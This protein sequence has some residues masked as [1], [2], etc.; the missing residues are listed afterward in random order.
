MIEQLLVGQGECCE[1]TSRSV[2]SREIGRVIHSIDFV[3][4]IGRTRAQNAVKNGR[5]V[6]RANCLIVERSESVVC[7]LHGV[8]CQL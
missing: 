2:V 4:E 5:I 7:E 1:R 3:R 6:R 8:K